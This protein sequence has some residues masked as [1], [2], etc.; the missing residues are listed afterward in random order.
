MTRLSALL[1]Q[2]F[3]N[4]EDVVKG[5]SSIT[6]ET[7][8]RLLFLIGFILVALGSMA[9]AAFIRKRGK[10]RRVRVPPPTWKH[11]PEKSPR[12]HRRRQR[13]RRTEHRERPANPTLSE[14]GGLPPPKDDEAAPDW[15]EL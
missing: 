4:P 9:W 1:A 2:E 11:P 8:D 12:S 15:T 6:P 5:W 7:R 3:I 14:T 10:K 13:I